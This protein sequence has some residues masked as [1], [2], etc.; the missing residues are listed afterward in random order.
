MNPIA[1]VGRAGLFP[2]SPTLSVFWENIIAQRDMTSDALTSRWRLNPMSTLG[3]IQDGVRSLRGGYV[4]DTTTTMIDPASVDLSAEEYNTLDT[5]HRWVLQTALGALADGARITHVRTGLILGN[6]SFPTDS[7]TGLAEDIWFPSVPKGARGVHPTHRFMSGRPALLAKKALGLGG[8]AWALDCACASGLISIQ[9]GC[10]ALLSGQ[11]DAV[12]A[13][14]VNRADDL[15]IHMGF[16][17]LQALSATGRS[18]P[19][20]AEA[21]GLVPAEGAGFVLL[22]RLD[23]AVRD[24]DPIFGVIRGVGVSNDGRGKGLLVPSSNGQVRAMK[25]AYQRA[26]VDPETVQVVEC[27]ATGTVLGDGTELRSMASVFTHNPWVTS[28][29]ANMG[30]G[31]TAAGIA[32]VI[33]TLESFRHDVIPA[34][35]KVET[36]NM[37]LQQ[38][39]FRLPQENV[40]WNTSQV[41]RV[42]VSAFGFGGNNAHLIIDSWAESTYVPAASTLSPNNRSQSVAIVAVD[43][44]V[45]ACTDLGQVRRGL[46]TGDWASLQAPVREVTLD[47]AWVKF[48]PNDLAQSLPQQNLLLRLAQSCSEQCDWDHTRTGV[49]V[50]M[51]T[52]VN[53]CRYGARW[54]VAEWGERLGFEVDEMLQQKMVAPLQSAG[55]LGCMPNIPANRLNS[56]LDCQGASGTVSAEEGSSLMALQLAINALQRQEID[57]A[58]V[59]AVDC[60]TNPLH[61]ACKS[62]VQ[63]APVTGLDGAAMVVLKRLDEVQ[64]KDVLAYLQVADK[65]QLVTEPVQT[66][67]IECG[68]AHAASGMLSVAL[69]VIS[70]RTEC[71]DS[72]DMLGNTKR[73]LVSSQTRQAP[74]AIV[75][76]RPITMSF[77]PF[78]PMT[79]G[80]S[81]PLAPSVLST[82][83]KIPSPVFNSVASQSPTAGVSLSESLDS[84]Q[85]TEK[86]L[87]SPS[88]PPFDSENVVNLSNLWWQEWQ[89]LQH[90]HQQF[91]TQQS[92]LHQQFLQWNA[93]MTQLL[94]QQEITTGIG[95]APTQKMPSPELP[96]VEASQKSTLLKS[97]ISVQKSEGTQTKVTPNLLSHEVAETA[98]VAV[99][100]TLSREQLMV[101]ASGNISEIYGD[102][103]KPQDQY[104]LQTR[105]PEPP[106]LL[107]DRMTGLEAEAGSMKLGTI[108]TETDVREDSWFNHVGRMP[109]GIM[110]ESGQADLMLISY[111]GIDLL[112]KGERA[113]R[114]LG[115]ELMYHDD[116]PAVGDTLCYDIHVDGHAKHGDV[117]LF[118]FHYDCRVNGKPRLTVRQGQAGFFTTEELADSDGILWTPEEQELVPNPVLDSPTYAFGA[119]TFTAAQVKAFSESRPWE[120]FGEGVLRTQTHTRTPTIQS[121][122][123]LFLRSDVFVDPTGGP[124]GR[125]YL[126][127]TV[128]ISPDD[129]FF[130]GHFKNDPCMPGTLMFEGCLQAMAF[131]LASMG[132][133]ADRDGWRFQPVP[134]RPYPLL[135]RGQAL[136]TSKKLTYEIFVEECSNGDKPYV[137]ADLLCTIDGL[138]AFHA[139][140]MGLELVPDHPLSTLRYEKPEL[141]D[142]LVDESTVSIA[143]DREGFSFNYEAMV[144]SALGKPSE[145]FGS[146]YQIFDGARRVARLP[147]APYHF[148]SRVKKIDGELGT[149]QVGTRIVLDYDIPHDAWYFDSNGSK[150]MPFCVLLEAALQP[151]GWL[152]SAVGSAVPET[153]DL[154]FRNL[155][156]TGTL[157]RDIAPLTPEQLQTFETTVTI[158]GISKSA[159]MIIE[160]FEVACHIDGDL[161]YDLK[162]VFGFFPDAALKNQVGL[163]VS[164]ELRA[165]FSQ[166]ND[167][168]LD[169]TTSPSPFFEGSLRLADPM[170]CMIDRISGYLPKGGTHGLGWLRAE[171]TVDPSEWFF[172]AHFFQDP[173]QPGSLGIEAMIQVL[174]WYMIEQDLGA[175]FKQPRFT[176]LG[177]KQSMQWRYRGQ[178]IPE[179]KIIT[180]TMDVVEVGRD[181]VGIFARANASLWVDGKRIYEAIDLRMHIVED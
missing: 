62:I 75:P 146:M 42:G 5:I 100:M 85:T 121:G 32:G 93:Q 175:S 27:H 61:V 33:K 103:F 165:V 141:L 80:R 8:D 172:K 35:R 52:D 179:N 174:Q 169:L 131:Y 13:G 58:I 15:F 123:M 73:M 29:K 89:T 130:E 105:M 25:M 88:N 149:R 76:V 92:T 87:E 23:D 177:L 111:L 166:E 173:V 37:E 45:G 180:T 36:L 3:R 66:G 155:D 10:E 120:C 44:S 104:A 12:L 38:S 158:T 157:H 139:R 22:K 81:M 99:G 47:S 98:P 154:S 14:A 135:C 17:A 70:G 64:P 43:A 39:K 122:K 63:N 107:A 143:T 19:F 140:G 153:E 82:T 41:K 102:L 91:L 26:T 51:G 133:T 96:K 28:L 124:W 156:G 160:S 125:G 167:Y 46:E 86:R 57:V 55:V 164:P 170:L 171:K 1:I 126:K 144:A 127:T 65:G 90:Q 142:T 168:Q 20:S 7:M 54:R 21:D 18:Q 31:I 4:L 74:P 71:V 113:Y 94:L 118:F 136:P 78:V 129:W 6:L 162:T 159:G 119:T 2:N 176:C 24:G 152:A 161:I 53:V 77:Q 134:N 68:D 147:G 79:L 40:D 30:H 117:R 178:V 83:A 110:I 34:H 115:C 128:D 16:T 69:S 163:P 101:H 60:A 9:Q 97:V 181:D 116:L 67:V 150:V 59:A 84:D 151:C 112:T 11:M 109:A 114:L 108:W 72:V 48:P 106:L 49:W 95:V 148:M 56:Q 50:G 137:I 138:K 132:Y 145:A